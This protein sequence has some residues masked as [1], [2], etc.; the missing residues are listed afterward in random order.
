MLL[1]R[2]RNA[3]Q[4]HDVETANRSFENVAQ[5]RY[6]GTTVTNKNLVQDEIKRRLNSGIPSYHSVQKLLSFRLLSKKVRIRI[7]KT[8]TLPVVLYGRETWSLTLMEE[9]S[10]RVFENRVLKF[11]FGLKREEVIGGCRKLHSEELHNLYSSPSII[12]MIKSKRMRWARHAA[13]R[14]RSV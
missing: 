10:L 14:G 4:N 8:I 1:S 11:L 5:F 3:G 2:H 7:Y 12:R 13:R 9:H 6:L